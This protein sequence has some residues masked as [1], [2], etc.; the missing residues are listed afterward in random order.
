MSGG[1][2]KLSVLFIITF[3]NRAVAENQISNYHMIQQSC[4]WVYI[5]TKLQK[6]T[7]TP[8]SIAALFTIA[9]A[10]KQP[11]CPTT[12]EWINKTWYIYTMAHLAIK[13]KNEIMP[14]AATS[15]EL[16]ILILNEVRKRKAN[17]I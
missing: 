17:T 8:L 12:G 15:M 11:K 3:R 5:Q 1:G 16:E 10:R 2:R 13:K 4:C 7:C 6:D 14:F 9:K